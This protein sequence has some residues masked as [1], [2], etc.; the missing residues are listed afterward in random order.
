MLPR[1]IFLVT[2]ALLFACEGRG[3]KGKAGAAGIGAAAPQYQGKTLDGDYVALSDYKGKVVLLNV[4]A[5]WCAPC[6]KELPEL[7][8]LQSKHGGEAF[9]VLGVS[10]DNPGAKGRLEAMVRQFRL[11]YP[12][13]HDPDGSGLDPFTIRGYPTSFLIGKDGT[14]LWRRDGLIEPNDGELG[15]QLKAAL[16][17]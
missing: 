15:G 13:V 12:I 6:R 17:G 8:A 2:P 5:T 7:V 3:A 9:T 11:N 16:A 10:I 1:R 14:L 4:W